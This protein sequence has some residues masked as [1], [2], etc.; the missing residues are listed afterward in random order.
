MSLVIRRAAHD[1]AEVLADLLRRA[2]RDVAER[3]DLSRDN[4]PTHASNCEAGW[5]RS[6]LERGVS[7]F[8]ASSDGSAVGCIALEPAEDAV[9]YLEGKE[10]G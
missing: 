1:D 3:F 8:L 6:D 2:F 4:A 7:Y 5:V 9:A 10:E